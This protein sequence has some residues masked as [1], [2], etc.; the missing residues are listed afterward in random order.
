MNQYFNNTYYVQCGKA[1]FGR[2]LWPTKIIA[3]H[4]WTVTVEIHFK[5]KTCR[6]QENWNENLHDCKFCLI[7]QQCNSNIFLKSFIKKYSRNVNWAGKISIYSVTVIISAFM[8]CLYDVETTL[9]FVETTYCYAH[10]VIWLATIQKLVTLFCDLLLQHLPRSL[11]HSSPSVSDE[12]YIYIYLNF[13]I[14]V[15]KFDSA[16]I[17]L[18]TSVNKF[19]AIAQFCVTC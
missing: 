15:N 2:R 10:F 5:K 12:I 1:K 18:Y 3:H 8:R 13:N 14:S 11:S 4:I 6:I 19:T 9:Y 7:Y 16:F 17:T